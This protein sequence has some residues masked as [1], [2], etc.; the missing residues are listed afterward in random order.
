MAK[1]DPYQGVLAEI[2]GVTG[3]IREQTGIDGLLHAQIDALIKSAKRAQELEQAIEIVG[4]RRGLT[5]TI[6]EVLIGLC[7]G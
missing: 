4:Q 6:D 7:Q 3:K 2:A 1:H 5:G